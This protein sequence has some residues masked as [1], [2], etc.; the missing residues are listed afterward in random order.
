MIVLAISVLIH[1]PD[2]L[3]GV[4]GIAPVDSSELA[5]CAYRTIPG[6][7][8]LYHSRQTNARPS[9]NEN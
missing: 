2:E 1:L 9:T 4:V 6:R 7:N 5:R 8:L 3:A